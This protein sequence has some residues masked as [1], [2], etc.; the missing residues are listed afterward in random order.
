MR[1]FLTL[2]TGLLAT[3]VAACSN[4]EVLSDITPNG[5][6][7]LVP[8]VVYD[9]AS[10]LALDVYR[11]ANANNAPVV[12]FFYGK[13][14]EQGSRR[15]YKFVGQ[16]LAERGFVAVIPDYRLYPQVKYPAFLQDCAKAVRWVHA[17]IA[18]Y[19]GAP[20][21]IVLMGHDSGAY[22]AAMLAMDP[23]FLHQVGGDRSW[24]RGMVGLAGPYDFLPITDPDLRDLFGPPDNFERTQPVLYADGSNPPLLLM[25]GD[26]DQNVPSQSTNSLYNRVIRSGGPATKYDFSNYDHGKI[27]EVLSSHFQ[28]EGNVMNHVDEFV[29][30]VATGAAKPPPSSI[31]TLVPQ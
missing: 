26:K 25:H 10:A 1:V 15:E 5:G 28:G 21:K 27:L 17:N 18:G 14:W 13:R 22:N 8:A 19:G 20:D 11:P 3:V 31:Q 4:E 23:E 6:Y 12:V 16:A 29:R 24:V 30:Q 7:A 9:Q 2:F